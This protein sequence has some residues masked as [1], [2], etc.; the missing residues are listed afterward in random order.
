[1]AYVLLLLL[2]YDFHKEGLSN[3]V[4]ILDPSGLLYN[5]FDISS[6]FCQLINI[7]GYSQCGKGR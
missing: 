5:I 7:F 6:I 3:A 1:M 2:F 4:M